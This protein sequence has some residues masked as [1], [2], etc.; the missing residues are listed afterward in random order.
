MSASARL[1]QKLRSDGTVFVDRRHFTT[2][3]TRILFKIVT[4]IMRSTVAVALVFRLAVY[5]RC[6]AVSSLVL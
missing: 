3:Y 2:Q 4:V 1:G 6:V 5:R